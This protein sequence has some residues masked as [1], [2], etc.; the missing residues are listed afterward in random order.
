M[1]ATIFTIVI[2]S[3]LTTTWLSFFIGWQGDDNNNPPHQVVLMEGEDQALGDALQ[4]GLKVIDELS[5]AAPG[6]QSL[7]PDI[8]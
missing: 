1:V 2:R 7:N 6:G 3:L 5:Q 4:R 8:K